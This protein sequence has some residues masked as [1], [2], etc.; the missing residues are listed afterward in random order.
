MDAIF[1]FLKK[2]VPII[3][4]AFSVGV[5]SGYKILDA[6]DGQALVNAIATPK[7]LIADKD[8]FF[9]ILPEGKVLTQKK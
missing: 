1:N 7:D 8:V 5:F 3:F 6:L 2:N 4:I 9:E